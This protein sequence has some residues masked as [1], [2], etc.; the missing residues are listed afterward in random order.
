MDRASNSPGFTEGAGLSL[1][2]GLQMEAGAFGQAGAL[3]ASICVE[4][5]GLG[6]ASYRDC[7]GDV[8]TSALSTAVGQRIAMATSGT[9][10]IT[11]AWQNCSTTTWST[12]WRSAQWSRS[13]S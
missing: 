10:T 8:L 6:A 13:C 11:S 2:T 5:R 12:Q 1:L 4:G 9:G 7:W 3:S